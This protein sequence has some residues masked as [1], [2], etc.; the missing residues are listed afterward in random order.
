M[1]YFF[2]K[3]SYLLYKIYSNQG[4]I[5]FCKMIKSV[6]NPHDLIDNLWMNIQ[7]SLNSCS[8]FRDQRHE[9]LKNSFSWQND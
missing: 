4:K 9:D 5:L 1:K 7:K 3:I 8:F 2:E 6:S